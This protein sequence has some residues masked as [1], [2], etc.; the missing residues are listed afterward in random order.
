VLGC[1]G[2]VGKSDLNGR[3]G[4]PFIDNQCVDE[5]TGSDQ[6]VLLRDV[7]VSQTDKSLP[8][9]WSVAEAWD[10]SLDDL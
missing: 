2:F 10:V 8:D 3:T 4:R 7:S 5:V 9:G 1:L 6:V